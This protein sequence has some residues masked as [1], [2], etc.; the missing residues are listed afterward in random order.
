MRNIRGAGQTSWMHRLTVPLFVRCNKV[1]LFCANNQ[2]DGQSMKQIKI[3]DLDA[4]KPVFGVSEQK[5]ADKP[6]H[7]HRLISA[8]VVRF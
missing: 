5:S 4:R 7:P 2:M 8:F 3:L 1:G 6:A